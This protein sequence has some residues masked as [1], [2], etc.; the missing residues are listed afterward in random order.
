MEYPYMSKSTFWRRRLVFCGFLFLF[1]TN[2]V[3]LFWLSQRHGFYLPESLG[4]SSVRHNSDPY[5]DSGFPEFEKRAAEEILV[6]SGESFAE[7]VDRLNFLSEY[8]SSDGI[9]SFKPDS[10][11][12]TLPISNRHY[13]YDVHRII[14]NRRFRFVCE[15]AKSID[16]STVSRV[17]DQAMQKS[18][19]SYSVLLK[20]YLQTTGNLFSANKPLSIFSISHGTSTPHS[21]AQCIEGERIKILALAM[22]VGHLGLKEKSDLVAR[23]SRLELETFDSIVGS[24]RHHDIFMYDFAVSVSICNPVILCSCLLQSSDTLD[25]VGRHSE[26]IRIA[27]PEVLHTR[28]NTSVQLG[29]VKQD[30]RESEMLYRVFNN[31]TVDDLRLM[32][33]RVEQSTDD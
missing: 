16:S 2:A 1:L 24:G 5:R 21:G 15:R 17:V 30:L 33:S 28:Y 3:L 6:L 13:M 18:F 12:F 20:N 26:V 8:H 7:A 27:G 29:V 4:E 9:G 19:A 32:V 22:L 10:I 31:S 23:I 14:S 25:Q 11:S